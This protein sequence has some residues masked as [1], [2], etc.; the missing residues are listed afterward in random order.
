MPELG[1]VKY[2]NLFE[3]WRY[4]DG[5]RWVG[6]YESEGLAQEMSEYLREEKDEA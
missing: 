6:D 2:S 4:Y 1:D 3:A 5:K